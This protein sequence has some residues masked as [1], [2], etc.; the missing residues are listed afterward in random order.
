MYA[1]LHPEEDDTFSTDYLV[2]KYNVSTNDVIRHT[3]LGDSIIISRILIK[4][5]LEYKERGL[6][7]LSV[8]DEL[9]IKN[10]FL[11]LLYYNGE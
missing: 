1:L 3:A 11:N 10:I 8:L 7:D 5:L 6:N 4:I 2:G 9:I